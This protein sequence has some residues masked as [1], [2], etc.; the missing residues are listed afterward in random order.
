MRIGITYVMERDE[1][2]DV[3]ESY[4]ETRVEG[5]ALGGVEIPV[6]KV[7]RFLDALADLQGYEKA[8]VEEIEVIEQ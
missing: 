8:S 6:D 5:D 7:Q 2:K 3:A 4:V 1:G